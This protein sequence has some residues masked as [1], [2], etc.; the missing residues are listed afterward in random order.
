VVAVD[1]AAGF[2]ETRVA[3]AVPVVGAAVE[4][5]VVATVVGAFAVATVVT[6]PGV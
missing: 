1:R 5:V 3:A 6:V 2:V 4:T